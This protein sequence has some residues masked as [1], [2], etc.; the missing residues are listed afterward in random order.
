MIQVSIDTFS[1]VAP[2]LWCT[3]Q[4]FCQLLSRFCPIL[5]SWS[6]SGR[7]FP[8]GKQPTPRPTL[9]LGQLLPGRNLFSVF[10]GLPME[11]ARSLAIT[12]FSAL[13]TSRPRV[14]QLEPAGLLSFFP[15][16]NTRRK[17]FAELRSALHLVQSTNIGEGPGGAGQA[18]SPGIGR[19]ERLGTGAR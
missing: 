11:A 12:G 14:P 7:I 9:L 10:F 18:E 6:W 3:G 5:A 4:A 13:A 8:E 17:P 15:A 16:G 1:A 19:G 2:R